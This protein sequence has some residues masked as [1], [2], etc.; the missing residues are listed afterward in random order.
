MTHGVS[1]HFTAREKIPQQLP[2]SKPLCR[3]SR[4]FRD[5]RF[6]ANSRITIIRHGLFL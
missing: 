2:E 4:Y 6:E 1:T 5:I 3:A